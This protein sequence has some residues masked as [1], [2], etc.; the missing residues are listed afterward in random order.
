M[1]RD[2]QFTAAFRALLEGAGTEPVRLPPRSPNLNA[3]IERYMRSIK[4]EC[5]DR[6]IFFGEARCI[7]MLGCHPSEKKPLPRIRVP[8]VADRLPRAVVLL[9]LFFAG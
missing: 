3:W 5:L 1:D 6:M 9:L 8:H 7:P 4:S 2:T